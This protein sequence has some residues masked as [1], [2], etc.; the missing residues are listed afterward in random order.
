MPDALS[1]FVRLSVMT[2]M[3]M[4]NASDTNATKRNRNMVEFPKSAIVRFVNMTGDRN[5]PR[6]GAILDAMT[7]AVAEVDVL[8]SVDTAKMHLGS[9]IL[10]DKPVMKTP[11]NNI[12]RDDAKRLIVKKPINT[13]PQASAMIISR[14]FSDSFPK[15]NP[16]TTPPPIWTATAIPAIAASSTFCI[17][18]L[19]CV[20]M[21]A[22]PTP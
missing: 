19:I 14:S 16:D 1:F 4:P 8:T 9:I 13:A 15:N 3:V 10:R 12:T 18:C 2:V 11:M 21:L 5:P 7:V 22:P 6:L 17:F 20:E